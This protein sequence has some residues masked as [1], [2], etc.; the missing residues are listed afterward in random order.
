MVSS[1]CIRPRRNAVRRGVLLIAASTGTCLLALA[2][3]FPLRATERGANDVARASSA[4]G[5]SAGAGF[6]GVI[7]VDRA[8]FRRG[9][10]DGLAAGTDGE[11]GMSRPEYFARI[12]AVTRLLSEAEL[13]AIAHRVDETRDR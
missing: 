9:L 8:S 7:E 13:A 6:R 12:R 11:R 5:L 3:T 10:L 2:A 1:D 4:I